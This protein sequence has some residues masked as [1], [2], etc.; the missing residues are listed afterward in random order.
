MP[1]LVLSHNLS[2]IRRKE[3]ENSGPVICRVDLSE[4]ELLERYSEEARLVR[5]GLEAEFR[6]CIEEGK[7]IIVEGLHIHLPLYSDLA[8]RAALR[9]PRGLGH[10]PTVAGIVVAFLIVV[11]DEEG[12]TSMIEDWVSHQDELTVQVRPL[13]FIAL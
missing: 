1:A 2:A 6:K 7:S 3:K 5:Q 9:V 8:E 10:A 4:S 12:H 11:E 13:L